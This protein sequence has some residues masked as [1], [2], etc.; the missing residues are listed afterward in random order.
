MA[1]RAQNRMTYDVNV[2]DGATRMHDAVV[3]HPLCLL[4]G[5]RLD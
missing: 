1:G 4:A 5:G 3:R 2:P